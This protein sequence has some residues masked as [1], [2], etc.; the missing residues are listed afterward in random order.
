MSREELKEKIKLEYSLYEVSSVD[1]RNDL[2][3]F[4]INN[5]KYLNILYSELKERKKRNARDKIISKILGDYRNK[6]VY[7]EPGYYDKDDN[8]LSLGMDV[9]WNYRRYFFV[10]ASLVTDDNLDEV[11]KL[12]RFTYD[13]YKRNYMGV[14]R[15]RSIIKTNNPS[16]VGISKFAPMDFKSFD[17][18]FNETIKEASYVE[19]TQFSKK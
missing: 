2:V 10:L 1:S 9:V 13:S 12:A 17:V 7:F 5:H 16:L 4:I 14:S 18:F 19:K 11:N 15:A 3:D 6:D 8:L